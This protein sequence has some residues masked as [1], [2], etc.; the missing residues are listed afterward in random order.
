MQNWGRYNLDE[1]TTCAWVLLISS[2]HL[3]LHFPNCQYGWFVEMCGLQLPIPN[4]SGFLKQRERGGTTLFVDV[5]YHCGVV[6]LNL[7]LPVQQS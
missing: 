3:Q 5:K 4:S 2:A 1:W 6:G 7:D